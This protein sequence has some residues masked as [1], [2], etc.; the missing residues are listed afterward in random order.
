MESAASV[1]TFDTRLRLAAV[2]MLQID[3][4]Y[5]NLHQT[6]SFAESQQSDNLMPQ[7]DLK[8]D[9]YLPPG[10]LTDRR[11]WTNEK[12]LGRLVFRFSENFVIKFEREQG[13][14]ILKHS[15][16][17]AEDIAFLASDLTAPDE[18]GNGAKQSSDSEPSSVKSGRGGGRPDR[19]GGSG[20][21]SR[22]PSRD[23]E[24]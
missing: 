14:R 5:I 6:Y 3:F 11:A 7:L 24:D 9:R 21:G 22:R 12:L 23:P 19:G 13:I 17:S 2:R 10:R 20:R 4:A 16:L 18:I 15:Q 1:Q 8:F